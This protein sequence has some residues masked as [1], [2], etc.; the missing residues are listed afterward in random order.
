MYKMCRF[1]SS[2]S[3]FLP[4]SYINAFYGP[5]SM[6]PVWW[7]PVSELQDG[8]MLETLHTRG[9]KSWLTERSDL[10]VPRVWVLGQS[11]PSVLE[12]GFRVQQVSDVGGALVALWAMCSRGVWSNIQLDPALISS[13]WLCCYFW[14]GFRHPN[15]LSESWVFH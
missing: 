12:A 1:K 15:L 14:S 5:F 7:F 4:Q 13:F 8:Q 2:E 11:S 6:S 9:S 10:L 3:N